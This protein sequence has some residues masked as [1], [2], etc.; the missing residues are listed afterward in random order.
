MKYLM[1]ESQAWKAQ[2]EKVK[3]E[4]SA[5]AA[6]ARLLLGP[7]E[8]GGGCPSS[9]WFQGIRL[10]WTTMTLWRSVTPVTPCWRPPLTL[11]S[12][13][14]RPPRPK[15]L[16]APLALQPSSVTMRTALFNPCTL[17]RGVN[18]L[19]TSPDYVQ[20]RDRPS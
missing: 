5:V 17:Q 6:T 4:L 13:P 2:A 16:G 20:M 8:G 15:A 12:S 3:G 9:R 11:P 14:P 7:K 19:R 18:M 10:R 1:A